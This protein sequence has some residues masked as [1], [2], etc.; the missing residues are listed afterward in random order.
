M[1]HFVLTQH[2]LVVGLAN[3]GK[4]SFIFSNDQAALEEAFSLPPSLPP[5][6]SLSLTELIR[7]NLHKP[8]QNQTKQNQPNKTNQNKT[9]QNKTNQLLLLADQL[10][11]EEWSVLS[12]MALLPCYMAGSKCFG[13]T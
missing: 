2:C 1:Q 12:L 8:K 11:S 3:W 6:L 10:L 7:I 4:A 5:S 13:S 9:I